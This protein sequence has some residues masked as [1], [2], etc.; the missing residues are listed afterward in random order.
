MAHPETAAH[1]VLR[2]GAVG[3]N[4]KRHVNLREADGERKSRWLLRT[5]P[6]RPKKPRNTKAPKQ[7]AVVK[8]I[9]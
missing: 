7:N 4:S 1:R 9:Q 6:P 8:A 5:V 2:R 3:V